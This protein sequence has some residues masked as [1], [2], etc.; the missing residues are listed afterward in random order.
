MVMKTAMTDD[1]Q[2][3]SDNG[4][5]R[6]PS[7]DHVTRFFFRFWCCTKQRFGRAR[8]ILQ[9]KARVWPVGVTIPVVCGESVQQSSALW[10]GFWLDCD[11]RRSTLPFHDS[12]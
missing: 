5:P 11:I 10:G 12:G 6:I 2:S 7:T 8:L 4:E 3:G 1:I 9:S